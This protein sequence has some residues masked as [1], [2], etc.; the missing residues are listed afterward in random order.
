MERQLGQMVRLVDDLLDLSR[1]TRDRLELRRSASSSAT[2]IE[3]AVETSRPLIDS[4]GHELVGDAA[5]EP[6]YL[7]AD[8]ARLAQ[9]FANLLNN[10]AKYTDAG[11]DDLADARADGERGRRQRARHRHRHPAEKLDR[12]C[13]TCSRRSTARSS[14]PRAGSASA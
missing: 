8:P 14:A 5:A 12:A 1:I 6:F 4:A 7:N 11:G 3:H 2:V 9:V 13:S 10:A